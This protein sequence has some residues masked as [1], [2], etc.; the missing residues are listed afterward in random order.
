MG[1]ET[2]ERIGYGLLVDKK[3]T[4]VTGTFVKKTFD[5]KKKRCRIKKPNNFFYVKIR[6]RYLF[7]A[8]NGRRREAT[9][10]LSKKQD[11]IRYKVGVCELSTLLAL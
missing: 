3:K 11:S 9:L 7:D 6:L 4:F 2:L 8:T 5:K 10:S 1:G